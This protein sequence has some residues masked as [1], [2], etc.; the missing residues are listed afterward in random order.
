[1]KIAVIKG[2]GIGVEIINEALKVLEKIAQIY[3]HNFEFEE[4]LMGGAA[5]DACGKALPEETLKICKES[6]AVLFGAIGGA[7]W[8][9]EP[10]HNR[11]EAGLLALRKGL[12]LYANLRPA[13]VMKELSSSSPL[14]TEILDKGIDFIIVRELIGGIYFG[15]HERFV[16][17]GQ[18]WAKDELEY[19]Q[20]QIKQ[21]AKI[22]FELAL[23]R[24]KKLLCVDKAN[25]LESSRLWR[26]VVQDMASSYPEVN[27]SF[28]YV[29]NAAMQLCKNP[30]E[31]DVIL[32]ENMF[33]DILSDEASVLSGSLGVLPSASL[34]D[35]NFGL[36]EPIHGSAPDIAG[37]N[38]ANP[39]GAI[40][41]AA[42]MLELSLNLQNEAKAIRKAVQ[43]TLKQG[44]RTADI[45]ANEG[46]KITCSEMGEKICENL[47]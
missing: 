29:D 27:L 18:L 45:Y 38:L 14:K 33:G 28:M 46:I 44:Y 26:E 25:V 3:K 39:I 41:S 4:V 10:A 43:T 21:I 34:S 31:F 19:S 2:D 37:L 6:K 35:N 9:N 36:Y 24:K 17:D 23:K 42:L 1:M 30:S 11:P 32:T 40:L 8:D 7:K 13:S 47:A 5:I 15:K 16:K 20:S 22:G 12:N